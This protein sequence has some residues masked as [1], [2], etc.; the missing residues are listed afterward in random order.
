M[1]CIKCGSELKKDAMFCHK[2]GM[3]IEDAGT[4]GYDVDYDKYFSPYEEQDRPGKKKYYIAGA[5]VAALIV[6]I[7]CFCN[8]N[9]FK[10]IF[11]KPVDYYRYV[12]KKN[13]VKN[14]G[15]ISGWYKTCGIGADNGGLIGSEESINLK[16]SENI[17]N[18]VSDAF[19]TGDL[20]F[21]SD[22]GIYR[23]STIY[24][25]V[26][27]TNTT[28]SLRDKQILTLNT[29]SDDENLLYIRIPELSDDYVAFNK[30]ALDDARKLIGNYAP[31]MPK[32][33]AGKI[34]D[35]RSIITSLPE[36]ARMSRIMNKYSDIVFDN[37]EDVSRSGRETLEIGGIGQKCWI[38]TVKPGY[39]EMMK[40]TGVLRDTLKE[41]EDVKEIIVKKAEAGGYDGDDAWDAFI[42]SL[43]VFEGFAASCPDV[44]MK[45][46]VDSRGKIICREIDLNDY[47]QYKIKYGRTIKGREF[48]A[49]LYVSGGP[50]DYN[51]EFNIEGSGKKAGS[52]Y[53]GDFTLSFSDM[54][55][56]G[57]TLNSF[58]HKAFESQ[59]LSGQISVSAGDITDALGAD[60]PAF[61]FVKDYLAVFKVESPDTGAYDVELKLADSKAEPIICTYSYRRTGGSRIT[62]PADAVMV[63][64]LTDLKGY[65]QAAD[66]DRV[67]NNLKGAGVPESITKYIDYI[68]RAADYIEYVDLLL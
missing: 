9:T 3:R 12:E 27:S 68:E 47:S 14:I 31:A 41:D 20:G 8:T 54:D 15:L 62:L 34:K 39:R 1:R 52:H 7:L 44:E 21:L 48:G 22:I 28:V 19:G 58:D 5:V 33:N 40:L 6:F 2:C 61:E 24:D 65:L 59:K 46:Y 66:F 49:Q 56:I 16:L 25:N 32:G 18:P 35:Y 55:S 26:G 11:Y 37:I 63:E 67:E 60:D 64:K 38:L 13:A 57:L 50:E 43:Y 53:S 29:V 4:D 51:R 30:S 10:R 17:L 45:V 23:K 42:D 36:A